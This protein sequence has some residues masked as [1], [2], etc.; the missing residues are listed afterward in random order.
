MCRMEYEKRSVGTQ[1]ILRGGERL[2]IFS[3]R[4]LWREGSKVAVMIH[5]GYG[6]ATSGW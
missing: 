6:P 2:G 5:S 3:K 4:V 1:H